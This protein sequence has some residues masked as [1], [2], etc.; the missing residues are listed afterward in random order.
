MK[1]PSDYEAGWTTQIINP[2]TGKPCS[3]GAARNLHLAE[4]GGA[5]AVFNAGGIAVLN[6]LTPLLERMQAQLDIAQQ[7]NVQMGRELQKA[8]DRNRA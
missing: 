7:L 8:Q 5:E 6:Q 4:K 2:K 1:N 3:G